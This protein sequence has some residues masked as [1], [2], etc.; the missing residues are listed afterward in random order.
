MPL[1][2]VVPLV[3][4]GAGIFTGLKTNDITN[5][6]VIGGVVYFVLKN[7]KVI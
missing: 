5:Y 7:K 2:F 6:I 4:F 3:A 1:F